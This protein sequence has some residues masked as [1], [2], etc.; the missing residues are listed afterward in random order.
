[1]QTP[2]SY[3]NRTQ[4][5]QR[6]TVDV[7][8]KDLCKTLFESKVA[9]NQKVKPH[10]LGKKVI[11]NLQSLSTHTVAFEHGFAADAGAP[12]LSEGHEAPDLRGQ[13]RLTARVVAL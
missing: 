4:R 6:H 1:M 11:V 2:S 8:H 3:R 9:S 12:L 10:V 5:L 13:H 7:T